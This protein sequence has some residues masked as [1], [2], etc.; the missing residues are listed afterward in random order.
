MIE[1]VTGAF[2]EVSARNSILRKSVE[3]AGTGEQITRT[4][5]D[6]MLIHGRHASGCVSSVEIIG[7]ADIPLRFELRGSMGTLEINGHHPGGYQC[8]HLTVSTVPPSDPQPMLVHPGL[9]GNPL[10]V[11]QLWAQFEADIR[12]GSRTVPSFDTA[13]RLT[14]LLDAVDAA[15]ETGRTME[16]NP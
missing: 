7:G 6:H 10:N 11:A 14:R 2:T 16:V 3:I 5:A 15:S 1:A 8:G 9:E 13:L 12:T 4:C